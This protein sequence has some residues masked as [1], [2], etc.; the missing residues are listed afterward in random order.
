MISPIQGVSPLFHTQLAKQQEVAP[1]VINIVQANVYNFNANVGNAYIANEI[2]VNIE[3]DNNIVNIVQANT[4]NIGQQE[5]SKGIL[6][7]LTKPGL[8]TDLMKVRLYEMLQELLDN[9]E[10]PSRINQIA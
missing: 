8:L 2:D 9:G 5:N 7:Y 10:Q 3:G 1:N 6:P 4:I